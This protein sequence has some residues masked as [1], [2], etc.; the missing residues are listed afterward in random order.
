MAIG[1]CNS[2]L[3]PE[4]ANLTGF[5]GRLFPAPLREAVPGFGNPLLLGFCVFFTVRHF[6]KSLRRISASFHSIRQMPVTST[7][8]DAIRQETARRA[9]P[10]ISSQAENTGSGT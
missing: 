6:L 10:A 2:D 4:G 9:R 8:F 1:N 3:G 5:G 7:I